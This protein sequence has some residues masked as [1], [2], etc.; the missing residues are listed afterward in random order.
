MRQVV[1]AQ[2]E[3]AASALSQAAAC[4]AAEDMAVTAVRSALQHAG[5]GA[6]AANRAAAAAQV[7]FGRA[8]MAP[9]LLPAPPAE[10]D[11]QLR[12]RTDQVPVWPLA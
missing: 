8:G 3:S 11:V 9:A 1:D 6:R 10:P 5:Q 12:T 4:R 2:R 7:S